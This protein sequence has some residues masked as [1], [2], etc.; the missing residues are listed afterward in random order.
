MRGGRGAL[1]ELPARIAKYE[2]QEFLGGGMSHVYRAKDTVLGRTVAVKILTPA[3]VADTDTKARF[4]QEARTASNI[5]HDNILA[6]YDFGE[7]DGKPYMVMEFL[8]GSTL[9][10]A[11]AQ[12]STGDL[13][14]RLRIARQ[15]ANALSHIHG[16]RIIHRDIKPDNIHIDASGRAKLMDFGVAK[17]ADLTLTQP[18]YV[19]GT[20]YYMAPEQIM[21]KP[22]TGQMDIYAFGIMLY[23]LL[24]GARPFGGDT[25][26]QIFYKI[27]HEPLHLA[28]M[29]AAGLPAGVIE[30]VR[31][32]CEKAPE[33]RY[34]DF[35]EVAAA[36]EAELPERA[37]AAPTV[38][39][40]AETTRKIP[41]WAMIAAALALLIAAAVFYFTT[42]KPKPQPVAVNAPIPKSVERPLD[43]AIDTPS[44]RMLLIGAGSFPFGEKKEAVI[45]P[46]YYMDEQ[47][48]SNAR[49][50]AF[51]TATGKKL[52]VQF[53]AAK[54][55][56]PVVN[57][58]IADARDYARWAG[59]RLPTAR[60]WEK[61]ARG[62][63]DNP[64]APTPRADAP[65]AVADGSVSP[66]HVIGMGGNVWELIDDPITPSAGALEHFRTI[67]KPP[68]AASEPWCSI[69][70]GS[71]ATGSVPVYE[72]SAIPERYRSTD[73]GFRCA[74]DAPKK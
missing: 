9:S 65:H 69:R 40:P 12:G 68:P 11:I 67:L 13:P 6:V 70:G 49:Y 66:Y 8:R 18:G 43:A 5:S 25:I 1:M 30:I 41:V 27:M 62:E 29:A 48:V 10:A 38:A 28:P 19:L 24:M 22:V 54:P 71:F 72:F 17:T 39:R 47:E 57:V 21:G 42:S 73:I 63:A 34:R 36:L 23:E 2:L 51:C 20:P 44:G 59:K 61:A 74:K 52:P 33:N 3:G 31:R 16:H 56:L 53:D 32:C 58:S 15:V 14:A 4:L 60:E 37:T 45:L 35:D 26:E 64:S 50:S 55:D 7:E 46:A